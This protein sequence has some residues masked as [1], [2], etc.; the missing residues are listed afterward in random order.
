[1]LRPEP[2]CPVV[3]SS[4]EKKHYGLK[5]STCFLFLSFAQMVKG[6]LVDAQHWL[7]FNLF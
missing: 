3:P 5:S 1:M 2:Y 4:V 6:F 7:H